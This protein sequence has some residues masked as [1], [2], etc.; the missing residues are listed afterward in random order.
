[1]ESKFEKCLILISKSVSGDF[2]SLL[3]IMGSCVA[4]E[5]VLLLLLMMKLLKVMLLIPCSAG[6]SADVEEFVWLDTV[7]LDGVAI[8]VTMRVQSQILVM[9]LMLQLSL[10]EKWTLFLSGS[11]GIRCNSHFGCQL[12]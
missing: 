12:C 6:S 10:C 8:A 3:L 11:M 5:S 1:M 9:L 4:I 7:A 2:Q